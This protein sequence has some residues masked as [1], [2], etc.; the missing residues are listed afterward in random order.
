MFAKH[1][2][3]KLKVDREADAVYLRLADGKIVE[4]EQ[5]APG[6]IV[7]FDSQERV[8]GLEVLNV[9]KRAPRRPVNR[10]GLATVVREK[11]VK[12]H[13]LTTKGAKTGHAKSA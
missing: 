10:Y 1:L 3:M 9:S 11:P 12:R 13:G 2:R 7:D 8:V 6:I 4:S 5:V